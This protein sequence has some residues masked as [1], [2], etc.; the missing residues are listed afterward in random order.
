MPER[1]TFSSTARH[2]KHLKHRVPEKRRNSLGLGGVGDDLLAILVVADAGRGS[3][4]AAAHDGTDTGRVSQYWVIF[5][6]TREQPPGRQSTSHERGGTAS[7]RCRARGI[8][9]L[10]VAPRFFCSACAPRSWCEPD[11]RLAVVAPADERTG[12]SCREWRKRHSTAASGTS[13]VRCTPRRRRR[14]RYHLILVSLGCM[15][16]RGSRAYGW[17]QT[18]PCCG[19]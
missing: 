18:R 8:W 6:K 14:Q 11:R 1:R 15:M 16:R 9:E 19:W 3:A 13:W 7:L 4:V 17:Q 2:C 10:R 12:Q 5:H